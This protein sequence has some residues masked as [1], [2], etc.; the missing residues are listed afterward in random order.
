MGLGPPLRQALLVWYEKSHRR[1]PW[2]TYPSINSTP[3]HVWLSEM[4]LQQTTVATV[5]P[6][7]NRFIDRYPT[8][9]NLAQAHESDVL[10]LWQGLGY[11]T[12]GR[13]LL[14][15]ARIIAENG[16]DKMPH[17]LEKLPGVGPYTSAAIASIAFS[18][19]VVPVDGNIIRVFSRLFRIN[20]EKESLKKGLSSYLK[21]FELTEQSGDF[22]QSLMDLGAQICKPKPLCHLCPISDFCEAYTLGD[23]E[24]F[25]L[26]TLKKEKPTRQGEMY[27]LFNEKGEI[28]FEKRP[29]KG[30]FAGMLGLPGV[31]W[32]DTDSLL[33]PLEK[34]DFEVCPI[35]VRHTFTHFH[36]HIKVYTG[37]I[38]ALSVSDGV[39]ILPKNL[40]AHPIPTLIKKVLKLIKY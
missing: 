25:P 4:M 10:T 5:I 6:Y 19:P 33:V 38:L 14:K 23:A 32:E 24:Q 13:N 17:E 21:P 18:H 26:K 28:L 8:I 12:R 16:F 9:Y 34:N 20:Q 31:G 15:A 35:I 1:L 36:L 39:W 3:Y 27:V 22:A 37:K 29:Q 40:H 30:L 7:F 11:Y 2:R